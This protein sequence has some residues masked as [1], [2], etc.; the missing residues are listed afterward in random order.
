MNYRADID[1]VR[2]IA[3]LLV[4][5]FH[6]GVPGFSG[7]F[8]GVDVFFVLSGYLIS[9]VI[10]SQLENQRFSFTEFYFRRIRRLFPAYFAV[11]ACTFAVA[12]FVMLPFDFREFGQSLAASAVY[13]SNILFYREAGYFDTASHLK[14][15]L[16]TWSLS[17][18]EQFYIVFPVVA[19]LT[20]RFSRR[21]WFLLFGA[22]TLMSFFAA[23]F[24][25]EQDVSAVFYLYP[26][27]AWEMFLGTILATNY[28]PHIRSVNW[29]KALAL[30]GLCLIAIPSYF[31]DGSTLFP[32][33]AA[34]APC[35][36]TCLLIHT[37]M[38][39]DGWVSDAL[40]SRVPV[41]IGK[42]SYSLY[43]WHWPVFVLYAYTR[44]GVLTPLDIVLLGVVTA[45][46]AVLTWRFIETP[47]RSGKVLFSDKKW[48]VFSATA[49]L[50][51]LA[52]LAGYY[53]HATNGAPQRLSGKTAEFASRANDL[54]GDLSTC[55]NVGNARFPELSYCPI[56]SPFDASSYTLIWGDSHGGAYNPG[57]MT[58]VENI[59]HDAFLAW[60][61]GCP[62]V[63]NLN[64]DESV[65]SKKID[66]RCAIRNRVVYDLIKEDERI[67]AVILVGRWSYYINGGGV[68]EDAE[69]KITI[70]PDGAEPG[71]VEDEAKY[72]VMTFMETLEQLSNLGKKVFVVEQAPEFVDFSARQLAISLMTGSSDFDRDVKEKTVMTYDDVLLRQDVMQ[73]ALDEAESRG[74]AT[75]IRTHHYFCDDSKCSLMFGETPVFYDNNH[76]SSYGAVKINDMF[77]PVLDYLKDN[78]EK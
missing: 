35:I 24:Y 76:I 52:I 17:V 39:H 23:I 78:T 71:S 27:R 43:L 73:K 72:F 13:I 19:W 9:S 14:P 36:G 49:A 65:S 55:E 40:A 45:I 10:F 61:G 22:L 67:N 54:F 63:L 12:Y 69:N 59:E 5:L 44:N 58:L 26:F 62:P 74:L 29:R 18:E 2:A 56:G 21:S 28:I 4:I 8:I 1:G 53:L 51:A 66:D 46:A 25:I 38:K 41:F 3:V 42:I 47:F 60:E 70:W 48:A 77:S 6:F 7:G 64:K 11:M 15:L 32:G 57:Y 37:C 16:H 34:L 20:A 31:Y 33:M 50:S 30:V 68:G 75:I